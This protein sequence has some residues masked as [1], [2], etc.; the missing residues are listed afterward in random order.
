MCK[1]VAVKDGEQLYIYIPLY[2]HVYLEFKVFKVYPNWSPLRNKVYTKSNKPLFS[3]N[4]LFISFPCSALNISNASLFDGGTL[5][6]WSIFPET[7]TLSADGSF[8]SALFILDE[9]GYTAEVTGGGGGMGDALRST[10]CWVSFVTF[11]LFYMKNIQR[12][13]FQWSNK[14]YISAKLYETRFVKRTPTRILGSDSL[15]TFMLQ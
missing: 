12:H 7:T 2:I 4:V 9:F 3:W 10:S 15:W 13:F 6:D 11:L 5:S 14:N 1:I 8:W